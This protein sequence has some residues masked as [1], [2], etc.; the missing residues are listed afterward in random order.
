MIEFD[1]CVKNVIFPAS[2]IIPPEYPSVIPDTKLCA[3]YILDFGERQSGHLFKL[4]SL[5][6]TLNLL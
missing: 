1:G 4:R 5:F 2:F 3:L 6:D